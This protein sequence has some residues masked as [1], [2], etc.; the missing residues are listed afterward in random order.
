MKESSKEAATLDEFLATCREALGYLSGFGFTEIRPPSHRSS[1]QYQVWFKAEDR[2]VIVAGEGWGQ[3]AS[4]TLEHARGLELPEIFLV[5]KERRQK[6]TKNQKGGV[7]TQLQ[8]VRDAAARLREYGTDFLQGD[9]T[10]FLELAKPLLP[11]KR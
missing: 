4:L 8:Q 3:L 10:R 7:N 9:L 11:Y 2:V 6:L 1:N 5:P